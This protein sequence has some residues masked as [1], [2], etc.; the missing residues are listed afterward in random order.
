[1]FRNTYSNP[2]TYSSKGIAFHGF[3]ETED[4]EPAFPS[5]FSKYIFPERNYLWATGKKD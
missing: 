4:C 1:M 5:I 3:S 2:R